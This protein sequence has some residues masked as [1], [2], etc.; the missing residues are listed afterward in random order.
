LTNAYNDKRCIEAFQHYY[1]DG[2][3]AKWDDFKT[4]MDTI[5]SWVDQGKIQVVTRK[6]YFELGE[7]A[8]NPITSLSLIPD[9]AQYNVG[10]TI[11]AANFTCKANL[12]DNTQIICGDDK[13]LDYSDVDTSTAGTYTAY[14]EYRGFKTSVSVSVVASG[15]NLPAYVQEQTDGYYQYVRFSDDLDKCYCLYYSEES[16]GFSDGNPPIV[17]AGNYAWSVVSWSKPMKIFYSSDGSANWTELYSGNSI[18]TIKSNND[19]YFGAYTFNASQ[20]LTTSDV[21]HIGA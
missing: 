21:V 11:T 10:D 1:L 5:K 14:L 7:F 8:T 13:I 18:R 15:F 4:T 2:T 6:Q 19:T 20:T 16:G 12:Q 9:Q 17:S 3:K